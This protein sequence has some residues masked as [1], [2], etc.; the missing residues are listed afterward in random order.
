MAEWVPPSDPTPAD[1][2]KT[3]PTRIAAAKPCIY[4]HTSPLIQL[5]W[6]CHMSGLWIVVDLFSGSGGLL[7]ALA[8]LGVRFIAITAEEDSLVAEAPEAAFTGVIPVANVQDLR[9][10]TL[11]PLLQK[12]KVSGVLVAGGAP[13]QPNSTLNRKSK[14]LDDPRAHLFKAI[15]DLAADI[16]DLPEARHIPVLELLENPVGR[17]CFRDLHKEAMGGT[18]LLIDAG[19]FGWVTRRR[20]Y[21]GRGPAGTIGQLTKEQTARV[22]PAEATLVPGEQPSIQWKGKPVPS[23]VLFHSGFTPVVDPEKVVAAGGR[24]AMY[25]FT[26]AFPHPD[27]QPA[28]DAARA[29]AAADGRRFPNPAYEEGSMLAKGKDKAKVLRPLSAEERAAVHGYP[30]SILSEGYNSE[31]Y[32]TAEREDKLCSMIGNGYHIP[33]LMMV[34]VLLS[35]LQGA[36]AQNIG[37]SLTCIKEGSLRARVDGTAFQP[38][39]CDSFPGVLGADAVA[40]DILDMVGRGLGTDRLVGW[41]RAF[42][43]PEV[44]AALVTLQVFWVDRVIRGMPAD[45]CGP[46]L[47]CQRRR[48]Q[49][50]AILAE[51]RGPSTSKRGLPM[52]VEPGVGKQ[53]HIARSGKLRSP[54][55]LQEGVEDDIIFAARAAATFG[56]YIRTWRMQ[57]KRALAC[58]TKALDALELM[59]LQAMPRT[60]RQVAAAKRPATMAMFTAIMRW[61]DRAQPDEYINGFS[62]IGDLPMTGVFRPIAKKDDAKHSGPGETE[63]ELWGQNAVEWVESILAS[64]PKWADVDE[65]HKA[66]EKEQGQGYCSRFYTKEELDKKFGVGQWRCQK[67]FMIAQASGKKRCIDDALR[68][69]MNEAT[70]AEETITT[71]QPD[72]PALLTSVLYT[73]VLRMWYPGID[74]QQGTENLVKLLPEWLDASMFIQDMVDAYRQVPVKPD[75][76]A[77]TVIAVWVPDAGWAFTIM[78][79]C[80]FGMSSAVLNFNRLPALCIAAARRCMG[81]MSGAFFDDNI[82][83]DIAA[84]RGS[85]EDGV[86]QVF[87]GVGGALAPPKAMPPASRRVFCGI[88]SDLG[89]AARTGEVVMYVKPFVKEDLVEAMDRCM[90]E[91][92]LTA[93]KAAKLRGGLGWSAT[94]SYGKCGRIGQAALADRQYR[95]KHVTCITPAIEKA[96]QFFKLLLEVVPPKRVRVVGAQG[97]P[98]VIYSD[99]YFVPYS[100]QLPEDGVRCRLGWVLFDGT[101]VPVGGTMDVK[102]DILAYWHERDQQIYIAEMLAVLAAT[103]HLEPHLRGRDVIWFLDNEGA[104]GTFVRGS[105]AHADAANIAAATHLFWARIQCRVWLEWVASDDNPSDG[106]SRHGLEDSWTLDQRPAWS[107]SVHVAPRWFRSNELPVSEILRLCSGS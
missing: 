63:G 15:P 93:A 55:A 8:A 107:L 56:P 39:V 78:Y 99:A 98:V 106:L 32:T 3:L 89:H 85:G 42:G 52:F 71:I 91:G 23:R 54:L 88:D 37:R 79:G 22:L 41:R 90:N 53:V 76:L 61:P 28:S 12:R 100:E 87:E 58:V 92:V 97:P 44:A 31:A 21:Y 103:R 29:R 18:A 5:P 104:L 77:A 9:A 34:L 80:P 2:L 26:R 59:C 86:V 30:K 72:F 74:L 95:D 102:E 20:L 45:E 33:S 64:Q 75:H 1:Y 7:V 73:E 51:Q 14:E 10:E 94:A 48:S 50:R 38:G 62:M 47:T 35:T 69:G 36:K 57:Q 6:R 13:C 83:I 96:F 65:I 66:T 105:S 68:A 46:Q 60:V 19:V 40:E 24:G 25:T 49:M 11:R 81:V 16:R 17:Q 70:T 82:G 43:A 101:K 4:K 67:R 27:D 84:G